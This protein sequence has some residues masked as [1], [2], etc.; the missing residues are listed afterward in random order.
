MSRPG[1]Q[2][3]GETEA[4]VSRRFRAHPSALHD[5]RTYIRDQ[6]EAVG[7]DAPEVDDLVLAV[8][9]A[10]ANATIAAIIQRF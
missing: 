3:P 1:S 9:E 8:S 5:I 4:P 6:S 10:A 2:A 7:L